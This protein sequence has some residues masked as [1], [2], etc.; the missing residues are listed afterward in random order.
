MH[1]VFFYF[2]FLTEEKISIFLLR[3][4]HFFYIVNSMSVRGNKHFD[5][6]LWRIR[7]VHLLSKDGKSASYD[8]RDG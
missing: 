5:V 8:G 3:I 7:S 4:I 6:H 1:F 2:I